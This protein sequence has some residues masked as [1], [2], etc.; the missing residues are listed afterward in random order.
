LGKRCFFV[1][2]K[3]FSKTG[4]F[5]STAISKNPSRPIRLDIKL[6]K[7]FYNTDY[8]ISEEEFIRLIH[9]D[10]L[11]R[12]ITETPS[13][14]ENFEKNW[15][16]LFRRPTRIPRGLKNLTFSFSAFFIALIG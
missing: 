4:G 7:L 9:L 14:V 1:A 8:Q 6:N 10:N 11:D 3:D 13:L 16:S 5:I 12:Q 15:T 2:Q